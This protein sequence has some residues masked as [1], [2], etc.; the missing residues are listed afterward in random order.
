MR[1]LRWACTALSAID[2]ALWDLG[3]KAAGRLSPVAGRAQA[4]RLRRGH[5]G[6]LAG[7]RLPSS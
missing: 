5:R 1:L 3:G 2:L 6:A 7:I 4:G